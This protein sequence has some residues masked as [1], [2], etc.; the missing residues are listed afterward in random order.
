MY[1]SKPNKPT[2]FEFD[3]FN[4][5]RDGQ[6]FLNKKNYSNRYLKIFTILVRSHLYRFCLKVVYYLFKYVQ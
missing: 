3:V 2:K 4:R 6:Y 5:Y 1:T